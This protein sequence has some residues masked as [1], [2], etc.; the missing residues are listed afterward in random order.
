MAEPILLFAPIF[1]EQATDILKETLD[2]DEK[3]IDLWVNSP[4]GSISA[5]YSIIAGIQEQGKEYNM[6]V[7]GDAASF[8]FF[9]L[10]FSKY[11]KAFDTSHFM[12]HRAGSFWE[13]YMT[14]DE[15]KVIED[16]N[17]IIRKK[18]ESR[19]DEDKFEE[20]TGKTF[21]DIFSMEGR[22]DVELSAKQA[23]EIGLIDEVKK[24]D[25]N[26]RQEIES[27]YKMQ[28]VA[29]ANNS[30]NSNINKMGKSLKQLIFGEKD[31]I[32]TAAINDRQF[33]YSKLEKG[34][35]IKA[36][37]AGEQTPISG[38]FEAD[39]K[40]ITVVENEITAVQ[41]VDKKGKEI[42]AL[43]AELEALKKGLLTAEM[44]AEVIKEI[45]KENAERIEAVEKQ[46]KEFKAILERARLIAS[47]P[48]L[49]EGEFN[50]ETEK[51]S[52]VSKD[53]KIKKSIEAKAAE[54]QKARDAKLKKG[55]I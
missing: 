32:L 23:K 42:D 45:N 27:Q 8:A 36:L 19:V 33:I 14:D 9:M 43:K 16:R 18:L 46:N 39:E 49:P 41:E 28:L 53:Y 30:N 29:L 4:G 2:S 25:V 13:D 24:L 7:L 22:L 35:H 10:L 48:K 17:K 52:S 50:D 1:E 40:L 34:E 15:K 37:G 5:G 54:K 6:T 51:D 26:K 38:T 3:V 47:N 11:N 21:D 20:V 31:P 44:V 12:F 55:G